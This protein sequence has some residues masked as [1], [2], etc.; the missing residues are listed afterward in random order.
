MFDTLS[1]RLQDSFDYWLEWNVDMEYCLHH[2]LNQED[3]R[4]NDELVEAFLADH[5]RYVQSMVK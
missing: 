5:Q 4:A 1:D 3:L 2:G